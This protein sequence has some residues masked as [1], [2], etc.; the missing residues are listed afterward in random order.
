MQKYLSKIIFVQIVFVQKF[1]L[2]NYISDNSFLDFSVHENIFTAK[3]QITV[4]A[5]IM[6]Q[7]K[8]FVVFM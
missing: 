8:I 4:G 6:R 7:P 2:Y 5:L 3:K 1:T